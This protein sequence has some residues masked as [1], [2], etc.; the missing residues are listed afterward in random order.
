MYDLKSWKWASRIYVAVIAS[1][2]IFGWWA[3]Y[4]RTSKGYHVIWS[5][6]NM[7]WVWVDKDG[8]P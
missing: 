3:C 2:L 1:L 6:V 7:R 4:Y 5:Q 8:R